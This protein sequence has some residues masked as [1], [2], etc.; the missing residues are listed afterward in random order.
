M[1]YGIETAYDTLGYMTDRTGKEEIEY[2]EQSFYSFLDD[3]IYKVT[4]YTGLKDKDGLKIYEGDILK[5]DI[6]VGKIVYEA[7]AFVL[8]DKDGDFFELSQWLSSEGTI[9]G[10]IFENPK[11][12]K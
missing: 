5:Q 1:L 11:L 6:A 4:E 10:N 8:I 9:I 12:L 3:D 2:Y 7:P